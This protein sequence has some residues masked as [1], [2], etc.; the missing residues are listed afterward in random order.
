[1]NKK[2]KKEDSKIQTMVMKF[3]RGILEKKT[4]KDK[5]RNTVTRDELK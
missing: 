3:L 2:E 4:R 5:T 1:M